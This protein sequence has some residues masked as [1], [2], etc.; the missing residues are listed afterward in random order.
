[1][2]ELLVDPHAWASFV[3]LALLEIVLGIDNIIFLALVVGRLPEHRQPMARRIGLALAML[4]R[5]GLLLSITWVIGLTKP[6]FEAFG[7][8]VSWRDLVLLGGGLFLLYKA[9]HEIHATVEGDEEDTGNAKTAVT[10]G[11]SA[12]IVQIVILDIVFSLDS[13]IT[14]VGMANDVRI[15]IAAVMAAVAVMLFAAGPVGDFVQKHLSVKMLA[16]AFLM[17]IGVTL[18]ADGLGFHIPKG[19]LYFA[20]AFAVMVESLTL[21]AAAR[22]KRKRLA[23]A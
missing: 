14:A 7:H 19:Y 13:V 15:M 5:I 18:V 6:L 17:L 1:M 23:A 20:V 3:T 8:V 11:F 2:L 21:I 16:L 12:A 10:I 9:T 4:M 22:R